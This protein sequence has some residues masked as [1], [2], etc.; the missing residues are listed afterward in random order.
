M[1]LRRGFRRIKR[2]AW[3]GAIVGGI[4]AARKAV[5]R[6]PVQ[7]SARCRRGRHWSGV[8]LLSP[9][10]ATSSRVARRRRTDAPPATLAAVVAE[11]IIPDPEDPTPAAPADAPWVRAEAGA[12]PLSHP[13]KANDNSMIYHVPGGRFYDRTRAER[14]YADAAAAEADGYRAAKGS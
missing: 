11:G 13:V 8:S 9:R 3:L 5:R 6:Q 1:G 7:P 10:S 4:V 12:C 14:C 2:L